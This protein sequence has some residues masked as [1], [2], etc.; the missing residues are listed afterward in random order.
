MTK[1]EKKPR[2]AI[3]GA[4]WYLP[5]SEGAIVQHR[6]LVVGLPGI[7]EGYVGT[8]NCSGRENP[9]IDSAR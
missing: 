9:N 5:L 7:V 8:K 1:P 6:A 3:Y 2:R 4:W